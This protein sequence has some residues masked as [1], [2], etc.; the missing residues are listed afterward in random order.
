MSAN[1]LDV[2]AIVNK[3]TVY[4]LS[5]NSSVPLNILCKP[6]LCICNTQW[7]HFFFFF[8]YKSCSGWNWFYYS[9]LVYTQIKHTINTAAGCFDL[10]QHCTFPCPYQAEDAQ[11]FNKRS[12][13][14][15]LT[16]A[17]TYDHTLGVDTE[18]KSCHHSELKLVLLGRYTESEA[19]TINPQVISSSTPT[20]STSNFKLTA[21]V[22]YMAIVV[23]I[24]RQNFTTAVLLLITTTI[25]F[26]KCL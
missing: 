20:R 13:G 9:S 10:T 12:K 3:V 5:Q 4:V 16:L 11:S 24:W 7:W 22:L 19:N 21:R 25:L 18:I 23:R 15:M 1:C 14:Q 6:I 26:F 8:F 2:I 17:D